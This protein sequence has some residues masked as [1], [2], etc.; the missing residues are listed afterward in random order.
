MSTIVYVINEQTGHLIKITG[1]T[2]ETMLD[3][4][5]Y[6]YFKGCINFYF[7]GNYQ[8]HLEVDALKKL[9]IPFVVFPKEN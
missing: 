6:T 8:G 2:F 1:D 7:D 4:S 3:F 5:T 9:N